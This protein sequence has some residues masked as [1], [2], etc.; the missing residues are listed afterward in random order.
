M[1]TFNYVAKD[2]ASKVRNG[3]MDA[4]DCNELV[5]KLKDQG[6]YLVELQIKQ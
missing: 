6:L 2:M 3:S 4:D 5:R 1:A